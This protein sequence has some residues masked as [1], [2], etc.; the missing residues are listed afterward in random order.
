MLGRLWCLL[1]SHKWTH[2][3]ENG[4][5]LPVFA[6]LRCRVTATRRGL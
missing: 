6:C 3:Y 2:L 5:G 1:W 4:A